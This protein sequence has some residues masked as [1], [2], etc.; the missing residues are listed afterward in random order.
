M[1][2]KKSNMWL[3]LVDQ[4]STSNKPNNQSIDKETKEKTIYFFER[5]MIILHPFMPFVTEEIW[6]KIRK[7]MFMYCKLTLKHV[8]KEYLKRFC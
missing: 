5:L 6:Q 4:M 3:E 1:G 8:E 7:I 2:N